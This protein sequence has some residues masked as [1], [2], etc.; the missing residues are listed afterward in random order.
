MPL[1]LIAKRLIGVPAISIGK[2]KRNEVIS[3]TSYCSFIY[4]RLNKDLNFKLK[5]QSYRTIQ[6]RELRCFR[7]ALFK[8]IYDHHFYRD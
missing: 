2:K 7:L 4:M 6:F 1:V 3:G 5:Y 8:S